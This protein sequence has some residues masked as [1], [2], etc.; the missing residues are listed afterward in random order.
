MNKKKAIKIAAASAIAASA[1]AAVAP[2]QSQAATSVATTVTNAQKAMKAP[3]DKY[4]QTGITKKTVPAATVQALITTGT[5]AYNDATALVKKSGGKSTKTYL[6][7]LDSYKKYLDRSK[8]Y[9]AGLGSISKVYANADAALKANTVAEL[10]KAQAELKDAKNQGY[11]GI[12]KIYGPEVRATLTATFTKLSQG[13]LDK[14]E[15]A[16]EL[17]ATPKVTG[18]SAINAKTLEVSFS[19]DVDAAEQA[20]LT[21]EVKVNGTVSLFKFDGFSGKTAKLVRSSGLALETGKYEVTIKG[22]KVAEK[23][24][25]TTVSAVTPKTLSVVNDQLLDSTAKATVGIQLKDQYGQDVKF[26]ESDFAVTAFNT[27]QGKAV[28]VAYDAT[29]GFYIDSAANDTGINN[30]FKVGDEVKVSFFHKSS[31]LNVNKTLKVV[32]GAQLGSVE[33]G[34]VVLPTGKDKLTEDLTNVKVPYT[35]KDQY[36]NAVD[37]SSSNVE[38]ISTD[39]TVVAKND[40]TFTT[41]GTDKTPVL[42]IA[43]FG[44]AGTATVALLNKATGDVYKLNLTVNEK[45]GVISKVAVDASKVKVAAG[46]GSTAYVA[47][48]VTDNYG[49]KIEAKD[50][51]SGSAFTIASS[52][53]RVISGTPSIVSDPTD[54]NYGKLEVALAST[55]VKGDVAN[56]TVTVNKTG[57]ASTFAVEVGEEAL[58]S[59]IKVST[60]DSHDGTLLVGSKTTVDFD[61][62]DQ[63]LNAATDK[64]GYQV[65]YEVVG[66]SDAV[67]LSKTQEAATDLTGASVDVTG[68]KAGSATLVAKLVKGS[69]E[70]AKAEVPFTV[71]ANSSTAYTYSVADIPTLFKN[72]DGADAILDQ[73][74]TGANQYAKPIKVEATSSTGSKLTVPN[75]SILSV[76]ALTPNVTVAQNATTGTW[77]VAGSDTALSA[78]AKGKIRISV[79]TDEGTKVIEKEVTIS[80]DAVSIQSLKLMNSTAATVGAKAVSEATVAAYAGDITFNTATNP[81]IWATDQFGVVSNFDPNG[82]DVVRTSTFNGISGYAT[83]TFTKGTNKVTVTEVGGDTVAAANSTYRLT[84][85]ENGTALDIPVRVTS[86]LADVVAPTA[87]AYNVTTA[88]N[89][90]KRVSAT[91]ITVQ[92]SE[93]L[94]ASTFSANAANGFAVAGA[95]SLTKAELSTDGK[96]VTLTGTGFTAATTVAYT[97]GPVTDVAGNSLANIA[98]TATN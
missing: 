26:T 30:E 1:F 66:S 82:A 21:A 75:S 20:K 60:D 7:K 36:G 22:E 83:D 81:Y 46:T 3:F 4:Y 23:T 13:K 35:A 39:E 33:F 96:T 31:G 93:A 67:T 14:V 86:A 73:G 85:V 25:E 28:T 59:Q 71:A 34:S 6:A 87:I 64:T 74:E 10:E 9:V 63:Y 32:A 70:V 37:L 40:V 50:Y 78:D 94:K 12:G 92:F 42:N 65:K 27:T 98:A 72:G 62:F 44:K 52:N 51:A 45:A 68:A 19:K 5:K 17:L 38:V 55:A 58:P 91:E 16:L 11:V 2:T 43:K 24:V 76:S 53:S 79:A 77:Y 41:T 95:G 18:V 49:T 47:L 69:E 54:A 84:I 48:N 97:A 57:A 88:P 29:K 80:K 8:A 89:S 61:I 90:F 15:A 56:V